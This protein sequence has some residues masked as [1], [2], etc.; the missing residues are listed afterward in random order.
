MAFG[1][2]IIGCGGIGGVHA[3]AATRAGLPIVG[4]W[5]VVPE[6]ARQFAATHGA[7]A[8]AGIDDLLALPKVTAV[9]VCVPN[10][11]HHPC[12]MKALA[13]RKHV[14]L[15]KPMAMDT[16]QCTQIAAAAAHAGTTLQIGFVCRGSPAA[17]CVKSFIDA[18]RF[19]DIRHIKCALYRRRGIPGLGGWF[20]T[21]ARSGGGPLIDL[22]V[23]MLDL[24]LWLAGSPR[25][26]RASGATMSG[27]GAAMRGYTYT[28]MWAGP[29]KFDGVCDV[30][31]AATALIRCEGGLTIEMN[32]TWAANL[33]EGHLK[34]GLCVIGSK[35]GAAFQVFGKEVSIATEEEGHL[36]DLKPHFVAEDP[37]RQMWDEQYR[38]FIDAVEGR[39]KPHADAAAGQRVQALVEAIYR[40]ADEDR[41]VEVGA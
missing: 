38:Q 41:E 13:A 17:R 6:R 27:L 31:D 30:E 18:G 33:P 20:T 2:G 15:E 36:V 29:P 34:D 21:K 5:D 37:E 40:S 11:Q 25:P 9:A 16:A 8:C 28:W 23:H 19:G 4:V 14:L 24:S 22:G 10:D 39:A 35:A 1:I 7:Q 3:Q 26:L 32:V 12:A